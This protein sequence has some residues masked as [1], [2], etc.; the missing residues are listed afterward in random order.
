MKIL[1]TGAT[2]F[3]G[4]NLV[5]KLIHNKHDIVVIVR[6]DSDTSCID[7]ILKQYKYNGDIN[8]LIV[9]FKEENFDGVIHLASLFL[10]D[11][12]LDDISG[13]IL[14][15]IE[16]GTEIL[17]ACQQSKVSWFINT[18]TFWQ[19]FENDTYNPTNLYAAT[20]QAFEDIA[21]YYTE[22]SDLIF[23]TIKLNDT[24]GPDDPRNKI[25][26]L[27]KK[28]AKSGDSLDMSPGEQLIDISYIEDVV[29]AYKVLV[30]H[31]GSSHAHQFKNKIY[32]VM[33]N[34]RMTLKKLAQVFEDT[35]STKLR[36]N[37]GGRPYRKREVMVPWTGGEKVPGWKQNYTLK[38]AI[39]KTMEKDND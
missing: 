27:W 37:W 8:D 35:S 24:F 15:N 5:N 13:L 16:F 3:I 28:I 33:S 32:A 26:H 11:H 7:N 25:F 21:R 12:T 2:G 19:N 17:E 1:I 38:E 9:F 18:G 23:T 20:K 29:N 39:N 4:R 14:S 22:T 36:I 34:E 10:A 30:E 6:S 31:L